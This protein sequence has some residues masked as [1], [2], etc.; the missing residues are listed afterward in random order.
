M[1]AFNGVNLA[2]ASIIT[3]V[4][5]ATK[6]GVPKDKWVYVTG[7]AGSNDSSNFWERLNYYSSPAIEYSIDKALESAGITKDKIDC[8]DF[9]S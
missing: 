9:Y 5:Y 3:S 4:E 8:F 1:N 6:L 7:G 2:S